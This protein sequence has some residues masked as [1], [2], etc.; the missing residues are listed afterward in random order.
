MVSGWQNWICSR[1]IY[2][3][4]S[5]SPRFCSFARKNRHPFLICSSLR[6]E[7]LFFLG[8]PWNFH[9]KTSPILP[10]FRLPKKN[11]FQMLN[12]MGIC[13]YHKNGRNE[14]GEVAEGARSIF[15]SQLGPW[16]IWEHDCPGLFL[17]ILHPKHHGEQMEGVFLPKKL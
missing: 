16:S 11:N 8:G 1:L 15:P 5:Q 14:R 9:F 7:Q 10:S 12:G 6:T 2:L 4:R 17:N 3:P 13:V